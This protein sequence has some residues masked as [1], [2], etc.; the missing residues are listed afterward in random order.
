M[1]NGAGDD[2]A[3]RVAAERSSRDLRHEA[4]ECH[5]PRVRSAL[6]GQGPEGGNSGVATLEPASLPAVEP[7]TTEQRLGALEAR[8]DACPT[9]DDINDLRRML[10]VVGGILHEHSRDPI[11]AA[12]AYPTSST[13]QPDASSSSAVY[14]TPLRPPIENE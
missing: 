10:A 8:L 14:V 5:T 9:M 12:D 4:G 11:G 13:V 6:R 2:E 1:V 3:A 7:R